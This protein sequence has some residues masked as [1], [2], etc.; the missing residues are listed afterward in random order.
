[1]IDGETQRQAWFSPAFPVGGFAYSHGIEA[2]EAEH[3]LADGAGLT[4]WIEDILALGTGRNDAILI[5]EAMRR[6]RGQ[7][8]LTDLSE[9]ALALAQSRERRLESAQQG[10]SF[11]GLIA[12]AWPHG[13]LHRFWP[14]GAGDIAFPVAVGLAGALHQQPAEPLARAYLQAFAS[15]LLAAG[16]RLSLIG[17]SEAQARLAEL[18]PLVARIAPLAETG[19]LD[20][21]GG[22][23]IMA[24]LMAMRH[25]TLP[26]RLFRS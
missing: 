9:L 15:N 5:G 24:D 20:D 21:L 23:S 16:L 14:V 8:D 13:D 6:V 12:R 1:M 4:R 26:Q 7:G 10:A 19:T 2:A 25:E 17:Q 22:A 18:L 11:L 3:M